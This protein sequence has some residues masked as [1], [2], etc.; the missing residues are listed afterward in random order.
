[1]EKKITR[2][3]KFFKVVVKDGETG[4]ILKEEMLATKPTREKIS[5]KF[6]KETGKTNFMIDVVETEELREMSLE[7]FI[8]NST[9]VAPKATPEPTPTA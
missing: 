6:I 7:T 4:G 5:I 2:T 8:S 3:F 1:M 9:I